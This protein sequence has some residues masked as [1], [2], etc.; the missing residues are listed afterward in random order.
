MR[1]TCFGARSG[2]NSITTLP[3]VV[4]S[5]SFSL[6][7]IALR[8]PAVSP[9]QKVHPERSARH[10]AAHRLRERHGRAAIDRL[11]GGGV[12]A[13]SFLVSDHAREVDD[14]RLA[15]QF[16]AALEAY[17]KRQVNRPAPFIDR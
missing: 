15:E 5:V 17:L 13:L 4:S 3:L 1:S 11:G 8:L 6:S 2:R 12:V 14:A 9:V 10:R 16:A 7:A